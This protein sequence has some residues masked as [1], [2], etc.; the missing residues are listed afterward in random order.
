M[1]GA[2]AGFTVTKHWHTLTLVGHV[3]ERIGFAVPPAPSDNQLVLTLVL[4]VWT[5]KL[6]GV[7]SDSGN[8]KMHPDPRDVMCENVCLSPL[9]GA[10]T[11]IFR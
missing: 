4:Q 10:R 2:W 6:F 5:L 7:C 8:L 1:L 11:A 3:T 9:L